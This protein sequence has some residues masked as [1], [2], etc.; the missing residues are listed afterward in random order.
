VQEKEDFIREAEAVGLQDHKN[1]MDAILAYDQLIRAE[2][3]KEAETATR[4]QRRLE[5]AAARDRERF[6][7]SN[8][9]LIRNHYRST[10]DEVGRLEADRAELIRKA[11][12]AGLASHES[13]QRAIL[14]IDEQIGQARIDAEQRVLEERSRIMDEQVSKYSSIYND[15]ESKLL[16]FVGI[17]QSEF[18]KINEYAE[19]FLGVNLRDIIRGVFTDGTL[20]IENFRQTGELNL[21]TFGSFVGNIFGRD[22]NIFKSIMNTF[23]GSIFENF[24]N[25]GSSLLGGLGNTV[26]NIFSGL[27]NAIGN[28]FGGSSSGG[29][30]I[31]RA[32]NTIG[33]V[34]GTVDALQNRSGISPP[35]SQS[36]AYDFYASQNRSSGLNNVVSTVNTISNV[37]SGGGNII[38]NAISGIK[39]FFGFDAGGYIPGGSMGLVGEFGPELV[40][41]PANIAGRQQTAGMG[42]DVNINFTVNTIDAKDFDRLLVEKRDVIKNVVQSA[43]N[44]RARRI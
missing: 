9:R 22:G 43:V 26:G 32:V 41:G 11:N 1:T 40:S 28:I 7:E 23:D 2:Q 10:L 34:I 19:L 29:S 15:M 42:G 8:E 31:S 20:A 36:S 25:I 4:E 33:N 44:Q 5:E 24:V 16:D 12:E 27:E 17:N 18:R 13:T 3:V 38:S 37:L 21:G 35:S 39:D 6:I 14:A 30:G